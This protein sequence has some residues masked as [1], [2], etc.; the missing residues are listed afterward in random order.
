LTSALDGGEW[1]ASCPG[2]FIP[3]KEPILP[4]W[5]ERCG[6]EKYILHLPGIYPSHQLLAHIDDATLVNVTTISV[7]HHLRK[8]S[9]YS[10]MCGLAVVT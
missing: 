5:S 6:E 3:G 4:I 1:S 9:L 7:L 10:E 8:T 2:H